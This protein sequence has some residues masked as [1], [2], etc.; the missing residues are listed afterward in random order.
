M[1][2]RPRFYFSSISELL[3]RKKARKEN[4]T[5]LNDRNE[6]YGEAVRDELGLGAE[7]GSGGADE[8]AEQR[9][10]RV[11]RAGL[12]PVEG[13]HLQRGTRSARHASSPTALPR[14]VTWIPF[15]LPR[16]SHAFLSPRRRAA[17][18]EPGLCPAPRIVLSV[19]VALP[20]G[21]SVPLFTLG[22]A[23]L[24]NAT[25]RPSNKSSVPTII[26]WKY[27]TKRV[28]FRP[29]DSS[30][31]SLTPSICISINTYIYIY[32]YNIYTYIHFLQIF[33][34]IM[35]FSLVI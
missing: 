18:A 19:A 3:A 21:Q 33:K 5:N 20:W 35:G 32:M 8:G 10:Q 31:T 14:R 4:R 2:R 24:L 15:R 30:K 34:C 12:T 25:C 9:A 28:C 13:V 17:L 22:A 6:R 29:H 11:T 23:H 1:N 26:S 7:D 16:R 27:K